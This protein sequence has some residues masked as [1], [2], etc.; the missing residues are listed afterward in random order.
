MLSCTALLCLAVLAAC[1]QAPA[2]S[3]PSQD[4]LR[5]RSDF[6]HHLMPDTTPQQIEAALGKPDTHRDGRPVYRL[7]MGEA[8]V[9]VEDQQLR[10]VAEC[11]GPH[12]GKPWELFCRFES[13]QSD[14]ELARREQLL[15]TA[16]AKRFVEQTRA[17]LACSGIGPASVVY[18]IRGGYAAA[19]M[20]F[21]LI[22][23]N[24]ELGQQLARMTVHRRGK[25]TV[26]YRAWDEWDRLR[27]GTATSAAVAQRAAA[28]AKWASLR[29]DAQRRQAFG[30]PD[31]D[32]GPYSG[33]AF[34]WVPD[35]LLVL[36]SRTP[37]YL[38]Q[39]GADNQVSLDEWIAGKRPTR[40]H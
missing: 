35:G 1:P 19:D 3:T 34:Y 11:G 40:R 15:A 31:R 32:T 38:Y 14:A 18:L 13:R 33:T 26:V 7:L 37:S 12:G 4:V 21:P 24:G 28:L 29:D 8:T 6:F 17:S 25:D 23:S 16:G 27:P 10:R 9:E 36:S 2:Q 30:A 39:P 5:K 20:M 22:A